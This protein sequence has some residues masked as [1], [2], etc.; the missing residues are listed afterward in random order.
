MEPTLADW[1]LF[2]YS[3]SGLSALAGFTSGLSAVEEYSSGLSSVEEYSSGLSSV[4]IPC[5]L[6]D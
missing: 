6:A 1:A 5:I 2:R 3:S 4:E